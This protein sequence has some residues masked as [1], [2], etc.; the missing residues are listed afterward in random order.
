MNLIDNLKQPDEN[1]RSVS[2]GK[3]RFT[4]DLHVANTDLLV[5]TENITRWDNIVVAPTNIV[6]NEINYGT[7]ADTI[8]TARI[9]NA[10]TLSD[11]TI[12][13]IAER[14]YNLIRQRGLE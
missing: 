9:S 6:A 5:S 14:V 1:S 4:Q 10:M 13:R 8:S 12:D 11:E 2:I 7:L 3:G